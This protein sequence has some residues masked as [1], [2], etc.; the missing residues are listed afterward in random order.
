MSSENRY[1]NYG[2]VGDAGPKCSSGRA[3]S[4]S[5]HVTS[6]QGSKDWRTDIYDRE[7][8][9]GPINFDGRAR[10]LEKRRYKS[11]WAK[12]NE[13]RVPKKKTEGFYGYKKETIKSNWTKY[14]CSQGGERNGKKET[15]YGWKHPTLDYIVYDKHKPDPVINYK[16]V[17]TAKPYP[18]KKIVKVK[19]KEEDKDGNEIE[20]EIEIEVDDDAAVWV[21]R[22]YSTDRND[23][24]STA[25]GLMS[26]RGKFK[27]SYV[28]PPEPVNKR[29]KNTDE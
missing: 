6:C 3:Q 7:I 23:N 1:D 2:N 20:I 26:K 5:W 17:S 27:Y 29:K 25:F 13:K 11:K 24:V 19:V 4:R 15:V 12:R 18:N 28:P 16:L 14:T 8:L 21:Q 22:T 10:P 9:H